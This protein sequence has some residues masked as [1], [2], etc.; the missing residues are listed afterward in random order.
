MQFLWRKD[1]VSTAAKQMVHPDGP[2]ELR[3]AKAPKTEPFLEP[4]NLAVLLVLPSVS[5]IRR[6][7]GKADF[8]WIILGICPPSNC[9]SVTSGNLL[10]VL[11]GMRYQLRHCPQ[12]TEL[13]KI[14]HYVYIYTCAFISNCLRVDKLSSLAV[15]GF[16]TA[17][18]S[19]SSLCSS[20]RG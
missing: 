11:S 19:L 18:R 3:G 1:L 10:L 20:K 4:G 9:L 7:T 16:T 5:L 14:L 12:T 2:A 6:T 8:E 13:K 15:K 17:F